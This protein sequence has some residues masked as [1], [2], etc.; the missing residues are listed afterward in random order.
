[1]TRLRLSHR[2]ANER[3][4]DLLIDPYPSTLVDAHVG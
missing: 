2:S 1:M 4:R 3:L